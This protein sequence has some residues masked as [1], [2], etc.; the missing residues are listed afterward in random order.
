MH[1]KCKSTD[2]SQFEYTMH[3]TIIQ[4]YKALVLYNQ[5]YKAFI[6]ITINYV[7]HAFTTYNLPSFKY[8]P[9]NLPGRTIVQ[10]YHAIQ[11]DFS[12]FCAI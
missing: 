2:L 10:V 8:I 3:F 4:V 5:V 9:C 11:Q 6:K 7:H 12:T 1:V